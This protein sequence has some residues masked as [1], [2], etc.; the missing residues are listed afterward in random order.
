[1]LDATVVGSPAESG[2]PS[3]EI[4]N[5]R[6]PAVNVLAEDVTCVVKYANVPRPTWTLRTPRARTPMV[7]ARIRFALLKGIE[8]VMVV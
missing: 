3:F 5:F 8:K 4:L 7:R 2:V 1:M 6:L